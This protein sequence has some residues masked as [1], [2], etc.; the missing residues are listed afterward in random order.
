MLVTNK[1]IRIETL[2]YDTSLTRV[3]MV[4]VVLTCVQCCFLA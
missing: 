4:F 3:L 2:A 1:D